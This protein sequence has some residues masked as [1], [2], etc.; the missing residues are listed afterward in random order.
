[1]LYQFWNT[2]ANSE[3]QL[4]KW[5][6]QVGIDK[7]PTSDKTATTQPQSHS[8]NTDGV[9]LK[10]EVIDLGETHADEIPTDDLNVP[11]DPDYLLQQQSYQS[12]D[13]FQQDGFNEGEVK[14]LVVLNVMN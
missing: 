11:T 4:L 14:C 6:S 8:L 12:F 2:S 5:L 1:M 13:E 9:I 7:V 10:Q 3:K